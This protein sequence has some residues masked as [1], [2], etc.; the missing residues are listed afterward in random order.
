MFHVGCSL[1][2]GVL[3]F[4][5]P[6]PCSLVSSNETSTNTQNILLKLL[7]NKCW[8]QNSL[9]LIPICNVEKYLHKMEIYLYP[10]I[11]IW[12]LMCNRSRTISALLSEYCEKYREILLTPLTSNVHLSSIS[13]TKSAISQCNICKCIL[14][15]GETRPIKI[16]NQIDIYGLSLLKVDQEECSIA[17][18]VLSDK[19]WFSCL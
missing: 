3:L 15:C 1:V 11:C 7:S 2:A 10:S 13:M 16:I 9:I 18:K 6:A 19:F 12:Y 8:E 14:S 4:V 17:R 5:V